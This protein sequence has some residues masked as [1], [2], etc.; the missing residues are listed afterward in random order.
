MSIFKNTSIKVFN[1]HPLAYAQEQ[2]MLDKL[3]EMPDYTETT[4]QHDWDKETNSV[5]WH[6]SFKDDS[7]PEW[8]AKVKS[9]IKRYEQPS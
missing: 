6:Y 3:K 2:I 7:N 4:I 5:T 1:V 8:D 9:I